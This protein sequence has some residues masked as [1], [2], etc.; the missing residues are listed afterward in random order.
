M[1]H[2]SSIALSI[3]LHKSNKKIWCID[4]DGVAIM[5][6]GAMVVIGNALSKNFVHIVLNNE[7]HESVGGIPTAGK[8]I[9]FVA[10][11][12]ACGYEYTIS[13][14]NAK[15][16]IET[17]HDVKLRAQL[18]FIEVKVSLGSSKNLG[19]PTIPPLENKQNFMK[20]LG[21]I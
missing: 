2:T 6:M 4:G 9:N 8:A 10:V 16:L 1:G 19:C 3:V 13:I 5:Y 11:A 14:D 18:Q 21:S 7:S 17:L 20:F 12:Q 15:D